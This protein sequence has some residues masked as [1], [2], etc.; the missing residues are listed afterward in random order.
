LGSQRSGAKSVGSYGVRE[1]LVGG[2]VAHAV[3]VVDYVLVLLLLLSVLVGIGEGVGQDLGFTSAIGIGV[4]VNVDVVLGIVLV[5]IDI[6]IF[7]FFN[8]IV[9][10]IVRLLAYMYRAILLETRAFGWTRHSCLLLFESLSDTK[11]GYTALCFEPVVAEQVNGL[12]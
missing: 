11:N 6:I 12:I 1:A 8:V 9:V 2:E 5:I 10:S 3:A 4:S 7:I